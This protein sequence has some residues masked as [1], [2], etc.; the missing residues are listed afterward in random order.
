MSNAKGAYAGDNDYF[1]NAH[2][3]AK[4][5]H[6][7]DTAARPLFVL[8]GEFDRTSLSEEDGATAVPRY[9]KGAQYRLLRDLG[10][11]APSD[12]PELLCEALVPIM[13]EVLAAC[14]AAATR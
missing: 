7:I 6:L 10:H 14:A 13:D 2:D 3:L 1:M 5:G 4:D 11:F 12:D 8:A 9:V